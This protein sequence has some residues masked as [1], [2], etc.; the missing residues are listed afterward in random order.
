MK[1]KAKPATY[2]QVLQALGD[3]RAQELFV[4]VAEGLEDCSLN[5]RLKFTHKRYYNRLSKLVQADLIRG[6]KGKYSLTTFGK[7]MYVE[8]VKLNK[9]VDNKRKFKAIDA[10]TFNN[11]IPQTELSK[12]VKNFIEK[13]EVIELSSQMSTP[14][15]IN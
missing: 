10:M 2:L 4:A 12:I 15:N 5:D 7:V 1:R 11:E 13:D 3:G 8:L 14:R 9:A 6:V